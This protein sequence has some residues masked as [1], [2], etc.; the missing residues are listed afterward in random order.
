MK[1]IRKCAYFVLGSVPVAPPGCH[2]ARS[3]ESQIK[4]DMDLKE[5]LRLTAQ[6]DKFCILLCNRGTG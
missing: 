1:I 2:S 6:N 5:I 3:E 4:K